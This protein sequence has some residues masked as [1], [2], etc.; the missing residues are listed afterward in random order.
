MLDSEFLTLK[1]ERDRK[2]RMTEK[3]SKLV[4]SRSHSFVK[5][6]QRFYEKSGIKVNEK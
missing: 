4:E 6:G 3:T 5:Q 2:H 1:P